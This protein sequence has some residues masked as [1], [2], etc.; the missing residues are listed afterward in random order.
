MNVIFSKIDIEVSIIG[1]HTILNKLSGSVIDCARVSMGNKKNERIILTKKWKKI[2]WLIHTTQLNFVNQKITTKSP[3]IL[4][5]NLYL[6]NEY[7]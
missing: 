5:T 7:I 1:I 6:E 2:A 3:K 4:Q